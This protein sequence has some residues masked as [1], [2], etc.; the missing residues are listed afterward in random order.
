MNGST[1]Y[2]ETKALKTGKSQWGLHFFRNFS[3]QKQR[4]NQFQVSLWP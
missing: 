2:D 4:V 3:Y 1:V